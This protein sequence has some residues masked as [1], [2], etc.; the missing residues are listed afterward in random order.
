MATYVSICYIW[1]AIEKLHMD[2]PI[3]INHSA[4]YW[5]FAY[6]LVILLALCR[7]D[8]VT[9][10]KTPAEAANHF[11]SGPRQKQAVITRFSI[12]HAPFKLCVGYE[13]VFLPLV[14]DEGMPVKGTACFRFYY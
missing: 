12:I 13:K 7:R 2:K 4:E 14:I 6:G 11:K 8:I 3:S 9:K 5:G 1:L 10:R